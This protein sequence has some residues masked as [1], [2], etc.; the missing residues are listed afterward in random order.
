[1]NMLFTIAF[2]LAFGGCMISVGIK[3]EREKWE[4]HTIV[5]CCSY[6]TVDAITYFYNGSRRVLIDICDKC[7]ES[8]Q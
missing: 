6:H 5:K 2:L 4:K 7:R 3:H 1:M 8:R